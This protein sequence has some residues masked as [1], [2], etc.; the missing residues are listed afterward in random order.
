[1]R[2]VD[3]VV[4]DSLV[5]DLRA[6]TKEQAVRILVNSLVD[7]GRVQAPEFENIV[8]AILKRETLGTTG[9]GGGVAIPH[10]RHTSVER[11]IG[12]IGIVP[13]GLG[14]DSKDGKPVHVIVL[15][16][17]PHDRPGDHLRAL[18]NVS[19]ALRRED[20]VNQLKKCTSRE[21][22]ENLL[23]NAPGT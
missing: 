15:I 5:P 3:F 22:L 23:D 19:S 8:R 17:S 18:E 6:E 20:F 21:Q 4:K 14:F 12:T 2:L 10:A 16:I 11:L 13:E 1:M 9:I 7:S